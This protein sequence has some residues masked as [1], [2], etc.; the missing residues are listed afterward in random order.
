MTSID[1]Y[2]AAINILLPVARR[3]TGQSSICA[4]VLLSAYNGFNFQLDVSALGGL[5]EELFD[6]AIV[7]IRGRTDCRLEPHDLVNNGSK[8][9]MRLHDYWVNLHVDNRHKVRCQTCDGFGRIYHGEE[10]A[11]QCPRCKGA[12]RV[13]SCCK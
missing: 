8:V 12:G 7:V 10:D 5:D 6:A 3:D 13:C 2:A 9:F 1:D 11:E 4:Q